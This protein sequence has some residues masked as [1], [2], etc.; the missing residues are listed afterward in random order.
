MRQ[1]TVKEIEEYCEGRL[2]SGTT[3]TFTGIGTDTRKDLKGQIFWALKGEQFDAHDFL[4]QAVA[5]GATGLLVHRPPT[6]EQLK[7]WKDVRV[8]LV[9]DTLRALQDYAHA[10]RLGLKAKVIG[11]TGS[12]GKTS[13]KEFLVSLLKTEKK[14]HWNPGSFN[15]H[16]GLPF[17]L[18]QTPD[19]CDVVIAE[20]GMNHAGE[21]TELCKIAEPDIVV[22]TMVGSAH[23][24]H[25]GTTDK[26]AAAKEEIYLASPLRAVRIFNFDNPWTKKMLDRAIQKFSEAPRFQFSNEPE[27]IRNGDHNV[28]LFLA[29]AKLGDSKTSLGLRV[30]GRIG[31][32]VGEVETKL[33]GAHNLVNLAAAAACALAADVSP[34]VIWKNLALCEPHW[35]R[36]QPLKTKKGIHILFDGYNANPESMAALLASLKE[37][38]FQSHF[39]QGRQYAVLGEMKEL[40]ES[41]ASAHEKLGQSAAQSGF[42][43]IYFFGPSS[44]AFRAG[45]EAAGF[46]KT[47]IISDTY[48]ESLALKLSSMLDPDDLVVVKASRGMKTERFVQLLEPVD[49]KTK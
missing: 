39:G 31:D 34:E 25:F 8:L 9:A 14:I 38:G 44:A 12:N 37:A 1:V 29:D 15:N 45:A 40:G 6:A 28:V 33:L 10:V 43:G 11:I 7:I 2:L 13:T 20:M 23:I 3:T 46:S 49:F 22:C 21:L 19:D 24:E 27:Q 18:I 48:E 42:E 17:N 16:F 35:G 41:A 47:L 4:D 26:I 36:M 30:A 32:Q 5:Q